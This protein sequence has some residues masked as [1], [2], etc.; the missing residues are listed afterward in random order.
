MNDQNW[1]FETEIANVLSEVDDT[2]EH[3]SDCGDPR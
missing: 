3:Q 1:P 2:F